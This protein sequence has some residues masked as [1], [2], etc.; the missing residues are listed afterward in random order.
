MARRR[1]AGKRLAPRT[2]GAE[3]GAREDRLAI[4]L[5]E[6]ERRL[7]EGA[8]RIRW[9]GSAVTH[10]VPLPIARCPACMPHACIADGEAR[11]R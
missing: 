11:Y 6:R 10:G 3:L 1:I 5:H 9:I 8:T 4:G 2:Q 7:R